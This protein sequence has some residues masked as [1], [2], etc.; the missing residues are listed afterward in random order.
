MDSICSE[1]YSNRNSTLHKEGHAWDNQFAVRHFY[2]VCVS[3]ADRI[4]QSSV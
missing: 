2:S 4:L 3:I 1:N